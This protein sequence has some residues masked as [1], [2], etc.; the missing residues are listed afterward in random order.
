MQEDNLIIGLNLSL[1]R[2]LLFFKIF[3]TLA[4]TFSYNVMM[5]KILY[6][7]KYLSI[8]LHLYDVAHNGKAK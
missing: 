3:I 5:L 7:F 8:I 6:Y 2:R 1:A 4:K